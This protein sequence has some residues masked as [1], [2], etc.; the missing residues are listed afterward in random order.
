MELKVTQCQVGQFNILGNEKSLS[1]YMGIY[2]DGK[3]VEVNGA[4]AILYYS[5]DENELHNFED[6]ID[7]IEYVVEKCLAY[8][9]CV[10]S[11]TNYEAQCVAFISAYNENF[12]VI[13]ENKKTK[14]RNDLQARI[15]RLQKELNDICDLPDDLRILANN[16]IQAKIN[17]YKKWQYECLKELSQIKEGTDKYEST[18]KKISDYQAKIDTLTSKFIQE[19]VA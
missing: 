2:Q 19:P 6:A 13:N 12:E 1:F 18:S 14:E 7:N 10:I 15:H 11:T 8:S 3:P 5:G 17:K 9:D 16:F 4:K